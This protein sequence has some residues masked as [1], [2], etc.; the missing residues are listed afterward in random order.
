VATEDQDNH[1]NAAPSPLGKRGA[2][3]RRLAKAGVGAAAV[4]YTLESQA[5]MGPMMCQSPSGAL[6]GGLSSHYGP[7][8]A[9][10]GLS[11]GFWKNHDAWPCPRGT[12][13]ADVF[14][15][16]GDR[17][18]CSDDKNKA[19]YLC[20]TMLDLLSPQGF[21][22]YKLGMHVVATYLNI[23]SGRIGFLTVETLI[24]MWYDVQTKGSYCPI[25][26]VYW[27]PEQVKNYL[28]A[29]HD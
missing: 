1:N 18:S 16:P 26:G 28:E 4:L 29:T 23:L 21:D 25:A 6:S 10:Q 13:F 7:Q 22:R 14:Y 11:P 15:V 8:P 20:A 2:A 17:S 3:R 12:M 27:S 19:S 24:A 9:C 5:A